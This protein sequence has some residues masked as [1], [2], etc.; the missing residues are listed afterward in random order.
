MGK[1]EGEGMIRRTRREA[2][3]IVLVGIGVRGR[4]WARV[5]A[6][7]PGARVVG[8]V[9][10]DP[11]ARAWIRET[12]GPEVPC[13]VDSTDAV[14]AVDAA[15]AVVAT[16]PMEREPLCGTLLDAGC[17]LLVEKPLT[18]NLANAVTIAAH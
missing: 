2:V 9:D 13:F 11:A 1:R 16:P 18:I 8:Y 17:D 3:P 7:E 4:M 10:P 14:Q 12:F 15:L 5:L 6:A